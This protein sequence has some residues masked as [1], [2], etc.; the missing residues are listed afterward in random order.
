M[1]TDYGRAAGGDILHRLGVHIG[2]LV[3]RRSAPEDA[4]KEKEDG[5]APH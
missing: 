1:V 5:R 3:E 2:T 4:S